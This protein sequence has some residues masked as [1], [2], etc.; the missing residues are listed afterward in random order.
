MHNAASATYYLRKMFAKIICTS[1]RD[2]KAEIGRE[3]YYKIGGGRIFVMFPAHDEYL[4]N[5]KWLTKAIGV[6]RLPKNIAVKG[7]MAVSRDLSMVSLRFSLKKVCSETGFCFVVAVSCFMVSFRWFRIPSLT[8]STFT[9]K[10]P[11]SGRLTLAIS[12]LA[13][14]IS[15]RQSVFISGSKIVPKII[16][17]ANRKVLLNI[18]QI[19]SLFILCRTYCHKTNKVIDR[20]LI[21]FRIYC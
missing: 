5:A 19:M 17:A 6:L 11:K 10:A 21:N 7:N 9:H 16:I 2:A 20:K 1:Y 3:F 12:S 15:E 13:A 8:N 4:T 14:K 18:S